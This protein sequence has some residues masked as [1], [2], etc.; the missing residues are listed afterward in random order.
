MARFVA[1]ERALAILK[2]QESD[3]CLTQI[4]TCGQAMLTDDM[5]DINSLATEDEMFSDLPNDG[6]ADLEDTEE[7]R[8]LSE[9]QLSL[10]SDA[11]NLI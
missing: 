3:K 10:L 7:V 6:L 5:L 4:C 1:A 9:P 8:L 2:D 11:G